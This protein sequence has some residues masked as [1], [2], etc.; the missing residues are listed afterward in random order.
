MVINLVIP[1]KAIGL[2]DKTSFFA[3]IVKRLSESGYTVSS[4]KSGD[5]FSI[6]DS[7]NKPIPSKSE[8][9]YAIEACISVTRAFAR[10]RWRNERG[11]WIKDE[12]G[13]TITSQLFDEN[14]P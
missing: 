3:K 11:Y 10:D 2:L 9:D 14:K 12:N 13:R 8:D 1:N 5:K 6:T 7:E 4:I